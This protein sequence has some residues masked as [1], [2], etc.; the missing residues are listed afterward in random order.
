MLHPYSP[1]ITQWLKRISKLYQRLFSSD[2]DKHDNFDAPQSI[3]IM[4]ENL[5]ITSS[6]Q[7][8]KSSSHDE[9]ANNI[10]IPKL[11]QC[12]RILFPKRFISEYNSQRSLIN[13]SNIINKRLQT[14]YILPLTFPLLFPTINPHIIEL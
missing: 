9:S 7:P 2:L 3:D 5:S 8:L 1:N 10:I 14:Y 12:K 6:Y 13:I 11:F 4:S